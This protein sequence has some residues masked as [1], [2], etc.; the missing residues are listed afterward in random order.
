MDNSDHIIRKRRYDIDWLRTLALGLLIIY[1]VVIS[2]QPWGKAIGFI[3]NDELLEWIWIPMAAFNVWRIP[4]LFMISGMG[5]CLAMERRNW[6]Q[7]LGDRAV[8]IAVPLIFG[9]FCICPITVFLMK[10]YY[11]IETTYTPN[12]G[13]LWFLINILCYVSYF[14]SIVWTLKTYPDNPVSR[15]I[16]KWLR[17]QPYLI[18]LAALPLML[19]AMVLNP[20]HFASFPT[21][22]GHFVGTVCFLTGIVFI[23][24]K[25]DFWDAVQK[26]KSSAISIA[27]VLFLIRIILFQISNV[28]KFL[29]AFESM[30]WMLA[31]FGYGSTYLNRPSRNLAYLSQA[32]FPVYIIHF[33][34]QYAIS[35]YLMPLN[36]PA[37]LKLGILMIGTFGICWLI[38]EF[39]I[40]RLKWIRPLFGMKWN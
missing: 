31:V 3:Q 27:V 40:K 38:Y 22:H 36:F 4:L 29:V 13:H 18:F 9:F 8:R 23:S 5:L 17:K 7:L 15:F 39:F 32:V 11:G 2:F 12:S 35:Y 24:I 28:P 33:P 20:K 10:S 34:I 25:D 6:L 16:S 37:I 14:I 19:E 30:C 26:V 1:H 21:P